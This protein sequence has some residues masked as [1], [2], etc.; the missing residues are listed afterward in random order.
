M[1]AVG[2]VGVIASLVLPKIVNDYQTKTLNAGYSREV[3]T[4]MDSLNGLAVNEN[5]SD[6]FSTM[7]YV[8]ALP[9]ETSDEVYE[10]NAAQY[11]KKYLRVS[12]MCEKPEDCFAEKYYQ[13]EAG[14]KREEYKPDYKGACAVLKNGV[15]LCITPQVGA[16]SIHGVIDLN[17]KKGPNVYMRDMRYFKI[18]PKT[19]VKSRFKSEYR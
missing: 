6:F 19:R 10:N 18:K 12:Q 9:E 16:D 8:D 14:K 4:I 11:M 2:I 7:M 15:S 1:I 17:G 13:Y 5:K 3:Q